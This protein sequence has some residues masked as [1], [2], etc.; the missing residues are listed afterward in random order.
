M[1]A[2]AWP[3]PQWRH[4]GEQA[5]LL[6]FVFGDFQPDLRIDAQMYRTRG[7]PPGI[8]AVRYSNRALERWD[9]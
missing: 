9:G 6:W 2:P 7:L 4:G 1:S 5:F 3:R 8:D